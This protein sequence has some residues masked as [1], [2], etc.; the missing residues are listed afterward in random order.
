MEEIKQVRKA[1][2]D[3]YP[4]MFDPVQGYNVYSALKVG[5]LLEDQGYIAFE[6]P[7]PTTDIEGLIVLARSLDVP[8]TSASS[9]MDMNGFADYIK[10]D[11][12]DIVRFIA[13]N[14][15]GITGGIRICQLAEAFG[16]EVQPHNW[17]NVMDLAVHF[18]S[19]WRRR[20]AIGSRCRGRWN[21]PTACTT[22]TSSGSMRTGYVNAPTEPGLGYPIDRDALDKIMVR[23]DK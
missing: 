13:D 8:S 11:A 6:D 18:N 21:S 19:N 7:I 17:G 23:I 15:G 2:G 12:L 5:R 3:D 22:R 14:I 16:M 4:L 1:A 20:T 9:F 10:R